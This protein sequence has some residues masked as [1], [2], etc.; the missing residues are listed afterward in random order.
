[1]GV[2]KKKLTLSVDSD[3]IQKAKE[4]GL[5]LSEITENALKISSLNIEEESVTKEKLIQAYRKVFLEMV[6]I[7]KKWD[8]HIPI[9]GY[10]DYQKEFG[11]I[12]FIYYLS[13][14]E[15]YLW[16]DFADQEPLNTWKLT[17][18]DLPIEHFYEPE[19]IIKSLINKLYEVA[20]ENKIKMKK[21]EIITNILKLSGLEK[22]ESPKTN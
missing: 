2:E 13:A 12:Q 17:D 9:G 20:E 8:L 22:E 6:P 21:L 14:N 4:L 18:N 7:L 11:S 1:M 19:K 16:S 10:Y 3:I 15:L 5:N